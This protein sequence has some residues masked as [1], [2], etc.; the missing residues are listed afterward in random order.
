MSAVPISNQRYLQMHRSHRAPR[1]HGILMIGKSR[2]LPGCT[3]SRDGSQ[4]SRLCSIG[5]SV[6]IDMYATSD[7]QEG[8]LKN[9]F[10]GRGF[11]NSCGYCFARTAAVESLW[12]RK[13]NRSSL[14]SPRPF[15]TTAQMGPPQARARLFIGRS[16]QQLQS[17]EKDRSIHFWTTRESCKTSTKQR[18]VRYQRCSGR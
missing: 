2:C 3:R 12:G 6:S 1:E 16:I 17:T 9:S 4:V 8:M 18:I 7:W 13:V 14:E 10:R 11:S 5:G 15:P